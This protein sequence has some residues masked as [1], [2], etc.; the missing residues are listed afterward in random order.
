MHFSV[1]KE[2]Q[3][4]KSWKEWWGENKICFPGVWSSAHSRNWAG[5]N[6]ISRQEKKMD[7]LL[8]DCSFEQI[9]DERKD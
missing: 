7:H 3:Q 8:D 4:R 9:K 5:L 6:D 2:S 1:E